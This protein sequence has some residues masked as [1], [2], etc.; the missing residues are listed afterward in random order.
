MQSILTQTKLVLSFA[1]NNETCTKAV[2]NLLIL[3]IFFIKLD[4]MYCHNNILWSL[5]HLSIT[6][7]LWSI[8]CFLFC[9]SKQ[10]PQETE[11]YFLQVQIMSHVVSYTHWPFLDHSGFPSFHLWWP[12]QPALFPWRM[13]HFPFS[14]KTLISEKTKKVQ[15]KLLKIAV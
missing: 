12:S 14:K 7:E 6:H 15:F 5:L 9:V 13:L 4:N 2:P 1:V 8:N 3:T 10:T 11:V